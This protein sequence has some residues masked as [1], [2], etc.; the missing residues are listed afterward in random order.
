V[1]ANRCR[2]TVTLELDSQMSGRP[3]VLG[4]ALDTIAGP[5]TVSPPCFHIR[6]TVPEY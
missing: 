6:A 3:I 2:E 4:V 5:D 1:K